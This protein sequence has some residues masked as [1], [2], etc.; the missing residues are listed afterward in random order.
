METGHD[1]H[2]SEFM[3]MCSCG[4]LWWPWASKESNDSFGDEHTESWIWACTDHFPPEIRVSWIVKKHT[5]RILK[6]DKIFESFSCEFRWLLTEW[7]RNNR[8]KL[9]LKGLLLITSMKNLAMKTTHG[10]NRKLRMCAGRW[11]N[12]EE[13]KSLPLICVSIDDAFW[14]K[15]CQKTKN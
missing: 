10:L 5:T 15:F 8:S 7:H 6:T 9:E 4:V 2:V 14:S 1:A 13:E 11:M 3:S 12:K